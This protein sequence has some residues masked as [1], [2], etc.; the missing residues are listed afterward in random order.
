MDRAAH[1]LSPGGGQPGGG[2]TETSGEDQ[3]QTAATAGVDSAGEEVVVLEKGGGEGG[4]N[5]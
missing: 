5:G 3:V 2:E 4:V 1:K